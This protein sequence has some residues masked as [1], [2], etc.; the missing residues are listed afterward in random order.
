MNYLTASMLFAGNNNKLGSNKCYYCGAFCDDSFLSID[1]VKETFTN[2][3]IIKCP[4]SKFV[5]AGCVESL[6]AGPDQLELID[7]SI[8]VRENSRGMQPRMYSWVLMK[9]KKIVG[10]KAHIKQFKELILNPP[11]PP[12]S[13]ILADSGQKQ[14]IFRAPIALSK[15]NFSILLEDVIIEVIPELLKEYLYISTKVCAALGKPALLDELNFSSWARFEEYFKNIEVL[16][17]WLSIRNQP[18]S[19][20]VAWLSPSKDDAQNEYPSIKC[21]TISTGTSRTCG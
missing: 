13:I 5:C 11:E 21:S 6:G 9:D 20:L 4:N 7:G 10:T 18:L 12:F 16:E 14:L 17:K 8:K 1:Y 19:R 3:D 2:R 15:N